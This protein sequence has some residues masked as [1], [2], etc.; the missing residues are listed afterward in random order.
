MIQRYANS[1][2]CAIVLIK[3]FTKIVKIFAFASKVHQNQKT[4]AKQRAQQVFKLYGSQCII[5]QKL[6]TFGQTFLYVVDLLICPLD[7]YGIQV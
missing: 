3:Y 4:P 5:C 6:A 7:S 1:F 2:T